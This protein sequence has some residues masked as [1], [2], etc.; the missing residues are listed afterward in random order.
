[1]AETL[2]PLASPSLPVFQIPDLSS[3]QRAGGA[4]VPEWHTEA[5][6]LG[7]HARRAATS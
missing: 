3:I 6:I 2:E 1:M 5:H 4:C 7:H